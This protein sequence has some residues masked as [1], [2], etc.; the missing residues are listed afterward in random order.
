M[1]NQSVRKVDRMMKG[2]EES[3]WMKGKSGETMG[4]GEDE[5][6]EGD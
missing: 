1:K 3:V 5:Q 6:E 4:R 2:V